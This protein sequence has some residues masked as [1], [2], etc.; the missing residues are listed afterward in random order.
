[1]MERGCAGCDANAS[2]QASHNSLLIEGEVTV[3]LVI[4]TSCQWRERN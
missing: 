2:H 1:M 4:Q 3:D